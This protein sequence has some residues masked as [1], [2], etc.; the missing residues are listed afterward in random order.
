MEENREPFL[1]TLAATF[2]DLYLTHVQRFRF[3]PDGACMLLRD[4]NA[5]RQIFRS[6]RHA[7]I[8]D[9]F[10]I[11]HEVA[12]VFALPPENLGG[13][14]RDGKLARLPR[15]TLLDVVKRRWD[16][17]TSADKIQL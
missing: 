8:D 16:Y 14:V 15:Q 1:I 11:L 4:V 5:Y 6:F 9:T 3:D 2:K 12:N 13:F 7:A 10:D 17:K